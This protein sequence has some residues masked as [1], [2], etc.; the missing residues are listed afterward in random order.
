MLAEHFHNT[1][2]PWEPEY[3]KGYVYLDFLLIELQ[4]GKT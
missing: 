1:F 3:V 4:Y 2:F